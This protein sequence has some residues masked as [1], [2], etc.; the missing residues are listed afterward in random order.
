[1]VT[2]IVTGL[3]AA[4]ILLLAGYLFGV[5]QGHQAREKLRT[6]LSEQEDLKIDMLLRQSDALQRVIEPLAK[7]D[8][9]VEK[10]RAD[11]KQMQ[12][13]IIHHDQVALELTGLQTSTANRGDLARLMDE[14]V[15]KA[16]FETVLLSDENGLPLVTNSNAKHLDRI[17]A[18]ASFVV[19]FG[20][21]ISRDDTTA[22]P[23]SF[24]VRD[25]AGRDILCRI[26]EAGNQRLVLTA[27]STELQL[28]PGAL[29]PALEK[30]V[31]AL[32]PRID[33]EAS[34]N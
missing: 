3:A 23:V 31:N 32:S 34:P 21:R 24:L 28:T 26:F 1:M 20:D 6:K 5:K 17:A 10:L 30:V 4:A 15:E 14:I 29:D 33:R 9:Q 8:E 13:T 11:I 18:I 25:K 27:V 12:S 7:W 22:R 2:T 16:H 19:I